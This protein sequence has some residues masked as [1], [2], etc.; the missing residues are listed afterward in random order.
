MATLAVRECEEEKAGV[1]AL[2]TGYPGWGQVVPSDL[3]RYSDGKRLG[4][5]ESE[6]PTG[7]KRIA[8]T[9]ISR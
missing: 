3:Y 6:R 4:I 7:G 2:K 1:F 5:R 8:R 9:V